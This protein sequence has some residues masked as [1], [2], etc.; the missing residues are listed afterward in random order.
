MTTT[1]APARH[2]R[3]PAQAAVSP[4]TRRT[5]HDAAEPGVAGLPR[6]F[7][8]VQ[9]RC[10]RSAAG[11]DDERRARDGGLQ[12]G[13]AAADAVVDGRFSP[14]RTESDSGDA[15]AVPPR[16]RHAAGVGN[17]ARNATADGAF[18]HIVPEAASAPAVPET[19]SKEEEDAAAG[20]VDGGDGGAAGSAAGPPPSDDAVDG[21]DGSI[22]AA[23]GAGSSAG[24]DAGAVSPHVAAALG[25]L[26]GSGRALLPGLRRDFE[27]RFSI[28]LTAVRVHDDAGADQL[29]Q[30]L[31]ARA[32][33]LGPDIFF[34]R[35][36][37]VPH[38]ADGRRLLAHELAHT[39]QRATPAGPMLRL[40]ASQGPLEARAERHAA[41]ALAGSEAPPRPAGRSAGAAGTGSGLVQRYDD[42]TQVSY[43]AAGVTAMSEADLLHAVAD[44]RRALIGTGLENSATPALWNNLDLVLAQ[45]RQRHL[46]VGSNDAPPT[47]TAP[48]QLAAPGQV[49]ALDVHYEALDLLAQR[50]LGAA[51][52]ALRQRI[53]ERR[54]WLQALHRDAVPDEGA[55]IEA[56]EVA[57][58]TWL[59]SK[60]IL[61]ARPTGDARIAEAEQN[62][63]R[64]LA[65]SADTLLGS[66]QADGIAALELA[67][68]DYLTGFA[69][70]LLLT[71]QS[72]KPELPK[73]RNIPMVSNYREG[74]STRTPGGPWEGADDLRQYNE[75]LDH[76]VAALNGYGDLQARAAAPPAE[77]LA[78][79]VDSGDRLMKDIGQVQ[80][81][82][83]AAQGIGL[84][85][86]FQQQTSSQLKTFDHQRINDMRNEIIEP[87]ISAL[88][89]D[90]APDPAVLAEAQFHYEIA[91]P[92]PTD[93]KGNV[94]EA[95]LRDQQ[96]R[97]RERRAG[98]SQS[99]DEP[100]DLTRRR[101]REIAEFDR[102]FGI[103]A[104]IAAS[105]IGMVAAAGAV[106]A[107]MRT[108]VF[109]EGG[110]LA[111][112][113]GLRIGAIRF[114][115]Q[116]LTFTFASQTMHAAL[117]GRLPSASEVGKAALMDAATM[118]FMHA[119]GLP[120]T[121]LG[122]QPPTTL[123]FGALWAWS[124]A[125][126]LG[127]LYLDDRLTLASG[128]QAVALSG[129]ETALMLKAMDV[130]HRIG[131]LP[132]PDLNGNL[133]RPRNSE[134]YAALQ[135]YLAAQREGRA[136]D[137]DADA[138]MKG[139]RRPEV[140]DGILARSQGFM[141][142]YRRALEGMRS[143]AML[144]EAEAAGLRINAQQLTGEI[145]NLRDATRLG[146]APSGLNMVRYTGDVANLTVYLQ[147]LR[148][149]GQITDVAAAGRGGVFEVTYSD[150]T[151]RYFYPQGAASAVTA[152]PADFLLE[153]VQRALPDAPAVQ[154][155]Q[156]LESLRR[157]PAEAAAR[158]ASAA[159]GS[160]QAA[161]V[162]A[163]IARPEV[164]IELSRPNSLY[165]EALLAD[166]LAGNDTAL[167]L[168]AR[169][170]SP[171]TLQRW[172]QT[173]FERLSG[174]TDRGVSRFLDFLATVQL[175]R[176]ALEVASLGEAREVTRALAEA[177]NVG[178]YRAMRMQPGPSIGVPG[179]PVRADPAPSAADFFLRQG[180][181]DTMRS[182]SADGLEWYLSLD[183]AGRPQRAWVFL[184][185]TARPL[186]EIDV[187]GALARLRKGVEQLDAL[188]PG[189]DAEARAIIDGLASQARTLAFLRRMRGF[190]V[191]AELALLD[192]LELDARGS[193][194]RAAPPAVDLPGP[195]APP[196]IGPGTLFD[197]V[198]P[199]EILS[200][201][202]RGV[203]A[204]AGR[205]GRLDDAAVQAG[206]AAQIRT[207]LTPDAQAAVRQG[208]EA[209]EQHLDQVAESAYAD[210]AQRLG[211]TRFRQV[212]ANVFPG[213]SRIAVGEALRF[214]EDQ[215]GY[216][217]AN[218][219]S[220]ARLP[221]GQRATLG[222]LEPGLLAALGEIA[223]GSPEAVSHLLEQGDLL[224]ELQRSPGM[225]ARFVRLAHLLRGGDMPFADLHR[226]LF[227][228]IQYPQL[229]VQSMADAVALETRGV[230]GQRAIEIRLRALET[231][232][233]RLLRAG[234]G[235][236]GALPPGH[237]G[238][239]AYDAEWDATRPLI[240]SYRDAL[241]ESIRNQVCPAELPALEGQ[242]ADA[243]T[244]AF[245]LPA[246]TAARGPQGDIFFVLF[247]ELAHAA[248]RAPLTSRA[249]PAAVSLAATQRVGYVEFRAGL[250]RDVRAQLARQGLTGPDGNPLPDVR[251]VITVPRGRLR[252]D[253]LESQLAGLGELR[254]RVVGIDLSG[255]E[256]Q[257]LPADTV[258][259]ANT[260]I[261]RLNF[262]ALSGMFTAHAGLLAEVTLR[263]GHDP[264]ATGQALVAQIDA[265]TAPA[266]GA[267]HPVAELARLN[268]SVQ[269]L[270]SE[271]D[272]R[273]NAARLPDTLLGTTVHAGEQVRSD[274]RIDMLLNDVRTALDA[275]A[276][277]IGH[278]IVLGYA[279][280]DGLADLGFTRQ[281][282]GNWSRPGAGGQPESYTPAALEAME[283]QRLELIRRV[284]DEK[285]TLEITPTSNRVVS[286][287]AADA[288]P[289]AQMLQTRPNLRVAVSTDNPGLHLTDPAREL[290]IA[291]AVSGASH[292]QMVRIYLEGFASRLGAR[293]VADAAGLRKR[294]HDALVAGTPP[295]ERPYVL[296]E[297]QARFGVDS[298]TTSSAEMDAATF[299][300]RLV[301]YLNLVIR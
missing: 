33:T 277:R 252:A 248:Q 219:D 164:A 246:E 50:Q 21:A 227:G 118:G 289:L 18:P 213:R 91:A 224:V 5:G 81:L 162:L 196:G 94:D 64:A 98:R 238:T 245:T 58:Q 167:R 101:L 259:A 244:R 122:Q 124:S 242:V 117:Y 35:G 155:L 298:G 44:L 126:Q 294:A 47:A 76:L 123:Q 202:Q 45:M 286:G 272:A 80:A 291:S 100:E 1:A 3:A 140:L 127:S 99:G 112:G 198:T 190:D 73:L 254:A 87:M 31:G 57:L 20:A 59:Q 175:Y 216:S 17:A 299:G 181:T 280:P 92:E 89:D 30:A 233:D 297:L 48:D 106:G 271:F 231:A 293:R 86:F 251:I 2:R 241:A 88:R 200:Q 166:A 191:H 51:A 23:A 165:A 209:A 239:E 119:V 203:Q 85:S 157:L 104:G 120:F 173:E 72:L 258:L 174:N 187:G 197:P 208:L 55:R 218:L 143:S 38:E 52:A 228:G 145:R 226:H 71:A 83:V 229:F 220:L 161:A 141:G 61:P 300:A 214:M 290:A 82:I 171:L 25:R 121:R 263:L 151:V 159:E 281:A 188:G 131:A 178:Y 136:V 276:D 41:Q 26:R 278:G 37:F 90:R 4:A 149:E 6:Y 225:A 132:T 54:T 215:P 273:D 236:A 222:R 16:V 32:F 7:A 68:T 152:P 13:D 240:D 257:P 195:L 19:V 285:V 154:H 186:K 199:S 108:A 234:D 9:L 268:R 156:V 66:V 77:R 292:P 138:W 262:N 84:V 260:G 69:R 207:P 217:D 204:R 111:A 93:D 110:A 97:H 96:Q 266:P 168:L 211:P 205:M 15:G 180:L 42:P 70:L 282:N 22:G 170:E 146:L 212:L 109:S 113:Q 182:F 270:V 184:P 129:V 116:S 150:G 264:V 296:L 223:G 237:P 95:A 295:A 172:Y 253:E 12:A 10:D 43:T 153:S 63:R 135:T 144:P 34:R 139:E 189:R 53:A 232:W 65:F 230:G 137:L 29:A 130:A 60:Q 39:L 147:R 235:I 40:A 256:S 62:L 142:Q 301:P 56:L 177:S 134:Q 250:S 24:D 194:P 185:D 128:A 201:R 160:P 148:R 274:A 275:G 279:L 249:L 267:P 176:G 36:A 67:R 74:I 11:R 158:L 8:A 75:S 125:W 210:V 133:F 105:I 247:T 283:R 287:M 255:R 28:S 49:A 14:D 221:A 114:A 107:V 103:F 261:A 179:R 206:L 288:H 27:R 192:R 79:L 102:R 78:F 183:A 265:G 115:V 163:F 284:G 169:S 269:E 243:L 193:N 46:A